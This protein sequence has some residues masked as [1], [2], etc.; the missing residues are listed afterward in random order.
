MLLASRM[1][2]GGWR[3]GGVRGVIGGEMCPL[4]PCWHID[5]VDYIRSVV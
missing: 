3:G 2:D 1:E 5:S 4:Q